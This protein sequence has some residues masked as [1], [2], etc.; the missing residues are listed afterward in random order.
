MWVPDAYE[1]A[2]TPFVAWLSV[3]PKA[4][5]FV[6]IFRLSLEGM[7]ARVGYRVPAAAFLAAVTIIGGNLMAI[8][9]Q[10]VKRLLAYSGVAHIGYMLV[11]F[12]AVSANGAAGV[13]LLLGGGMV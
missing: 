13:V 7:R 6:V 5:G 11:G 4:A 8:P 9:Q 10:N 3:A 1:A 12:A 2:S